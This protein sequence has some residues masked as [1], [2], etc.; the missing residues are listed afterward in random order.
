MLK[1]RKD[2]TFVFVP[3]KLDA[4]L[5]DDNGTVYDLGDPDRAGK[6]PRKAQPR[7]ARTTKVKAAPQ[8]DLE[9][10]RSADAAG[11][12]TSWQFQC[13]P[14]PPED[15]GHGDEDQDH[16]DEDQHRDLRSRDEAGPHLALADKYFQQ[17]TRNQEHV[18]SNG[19]KAKQAL[20]QL[21]DTL[22]NECLCPACSSRAARRVELV[23]VAVVSW[24]SLLEIEV[25]VMLCS[26]CPARYNIHPTQVD[27]LPTS[28]HDAFPLVM[29]AQRR[30]LWWATSLLQQF[31]ILIFH[32]RRVGAERFSAALLE[33]WVRNGGLDAAPPYS[34]LR[35][36]LYLALQEYQILQNKVLN[37]PEDLQDHSLMGSLNGCP[38]CHLAPPTTGNICLLVLECHCVT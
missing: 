5:V 10:V 25:P 18:I 38:C 27:C 26:N 30:P 24:D 12:S 17:Y 8:N 35:R 37:L 22:S 6:K 36:G 3:K 21:V 20:Q 29:H 1:T 14:E 11:P 32:L 19:R 33:N 23:P 2:G 34:S 13:M 7:K 28:L 15:G 4:T 16:R 31:D 9:G